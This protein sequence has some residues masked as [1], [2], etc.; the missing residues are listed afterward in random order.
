MTLLNEARDS[1]SSE[2]IK[3][4]LYKSF[5]KKI[6]SDKLINI[7]YNMLLYDEKKRF[8]FQG[9]INFIDE[10]YNIK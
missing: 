2:N 1:D 5:L 6:Y 7:I 9:L 4:I 10:N 8:N 3:R